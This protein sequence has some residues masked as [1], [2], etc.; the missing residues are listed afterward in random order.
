MQYLSQPQPQP[1]AVHGHFQPTQSGDHSTPL[2]S[3]IPASLPTRFT[4]VSHLPLIGFLQ[5]ASALSLQ[6]QMEHANQPT[7]FSDSVSI[8]P[9]ETKTTPR[10]TPTNFRPVSVPQS[11]LRPMH[12]QALHPAPGLL[13]SPQLPVQM[14]TAGK[15][16]TATRPNGY[17]VTLLVFLWV[18]H[19]CGKEAM[20]PNEALLVTTTSQ[21][22][23]L[24]A[25]LAP[26]CPSSSTART[27]DSTTS[28]HQITSSTPLCVRVPPVCP[29]P[30]KST[31]HWA[32]LL[33]LCCLPPSV[34]YVK[35]TCWGKGGWQ[36]HSKVPSEDGL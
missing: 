19:W 13:A 8:Q 2:R 28:D 35:V 26:G 3:V 11:S 5:P 15:V 14:Q 17:P 24:P 23:Q 9:W 31:C 7:S 20:H 16:R 25:N 27:H 10:G 29:R 33:L 6:K 4:P 30:I 12:P 32:L 22:L 18:A 21:A 36:V 1:Y 34:E